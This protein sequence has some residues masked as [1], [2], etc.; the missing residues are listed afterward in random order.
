MSLPG[1]GNRRHACR[2]RAP[3][4]GVERWE[5]EVQPVLLDQLRQV[6]RTEE[7][8]RLGDEGRVGVEPFSTTPT[9]LSGVSGSSSS[10]TTARP[11]RRRLMAVRK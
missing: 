3:G 6:V 9:K 5:L 1:R 11:R 2:A 8:A 10:R 4:S 7:T